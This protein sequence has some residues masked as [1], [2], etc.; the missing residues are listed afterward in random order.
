M[1]TG[2]DLYGYTAALVNAR[3]T[4]QIWNQAHVERYVDDNFYAFSRGDL[5]VALT[6]SGNSISRS[7]TYHPFAEGQTVCN[8][9]FSGDCVTVSGGAL[10]VVLNSGEAKVFV[11]KTSAVFNKSVDPI[12]EALIQEA[13]SII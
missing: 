8:V 9:L 4:H 1:N 3:K 12:A 2:T 13:S 11:P 7:V 5:F 6:N 10:S